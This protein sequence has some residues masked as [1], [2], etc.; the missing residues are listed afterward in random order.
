MKKLSDRILV[1][2]HPP[3]ILV[4]G[5]SSASTNGS[6]SYKWIEKGDSLFWCNVQKTKRNWLG[7]EEWDQDSYTMPSPVS[8]LVLGHALS[9]S[10]TSF[11]DPK[12]KW[13]NHITIWL[14]EHSAP[15]ENAVDYFEQYF[16]FLTANGGSEY[17]SDGTAFAG[18][19]QWTVSKVERSR[20]WFRRLA[21][22][23]GI[24]WHYENILSEFGINMIERV[25]DKNSEIGPY[26]PNHLN[27][28]SAYHVLALNLVEA[29]ADDWEAL[30]RAIVYFEK[31]MPDH[32]TPK[33]YSETCFTVAEGYEKDGR[34]EY[35]LEFYNKV[36]LTDPRNEAAR[37]AVHR[38]SN[39]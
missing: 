37:K 4:H 20:E 27:L 15:E 32:K 24:E 6:K 35:A 33:E 29:G 22:E 16:D 31:A 38:L 36:A 28:K 19:D 1:V 30:Y 5:K 10:E 2:P 17:I 39:R 8:G 9:V 7:K 3:S 13:H 14:S 21:L 11:K 34:L 25:I 18:I 23:E 26:I 12:N